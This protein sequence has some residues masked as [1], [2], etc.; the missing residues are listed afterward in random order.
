MVVVLAKDVA[1]VVLLI[2]IHGVLAFDN[3]LDDD[4]RR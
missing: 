4:I 1:K 2:R 3:W